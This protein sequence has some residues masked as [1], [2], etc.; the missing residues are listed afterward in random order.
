MAQ[1][2]TSKKQNFAS[3]MQQAIEAI[4]MARSVLRSLKTEAIDN[5]WTSATDFPEAVFTGGLKHVVAAD[6]VAG[7]GVADAL[8]GTGTGALSAAHRQT[9]ARFR[10]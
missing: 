9:I 4:D 7:I 6:I 3:R 8:D 1:D 2:L 10:G 5:G